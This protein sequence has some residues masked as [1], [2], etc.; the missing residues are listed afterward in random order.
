MFEGAW[1]LDWRR[2]LK[3]LARMAWTIPERARLLEECRTSSLARLLLRDHPRA[4]YPLMSHLMDRRLG[5]NARL[6]ATL[7]SLAGVPRALTATHVEAL[8]LGGLVLATLEDGTQLTLSVSGVS[9]HEGL[10][11]IGLQG[12]TGQRLYSAGFGFT[13]AHNV[14][15]ANVQGPSMAEGGVEHNRQLTHAAHGMRPPF[16]L[17]HALRLLCAHWNVRSL[18]GIDPVHHVKGRWNLRESRLKFDY[19]AFWQDNG[20]LQDASGNWSLPLQPSMRPLEEIA[21]KRRAMY[22]RRHAWLDEMGQHIRALHS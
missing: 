3:Y 4:F 19:R 14:L 2:Q 10:W 7:A 18:A 11:Q 22:R 12:V 8:T 5:A 1:T 6:V 17:V 9:F 13:A 20:G 21:A 16:L 15:I